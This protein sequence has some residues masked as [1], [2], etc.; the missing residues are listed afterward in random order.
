MRTNHAGVDERE[1]ERIA[2]GVAALDRAGC[3]SRE[4]RHDGAG[5]PKQREKNQRDA[6]DNTDTTG[7]CCLLEGPEPARGAADGRAGECTRTKEIYF[8]LLRNGV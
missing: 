5:A 4:V 3:T 8:T 1:A 6:V 2:R 7:I